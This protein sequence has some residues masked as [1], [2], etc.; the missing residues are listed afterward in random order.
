[1]SKN[2]CSNG[3]NFGILT[4]TIIF[5]FNGKSLKSVLKRFTLDF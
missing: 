3:K 4:E 2:Q 5:W 1:M